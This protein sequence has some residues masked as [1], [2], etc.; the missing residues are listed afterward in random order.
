MRDETSWL[1]TWKLRKPVSVLCPYP[2]SSR[3]GVHLFLLSSDLL[4]LLHAAA[5]FSLFLRVPLL[6]S[7]GRRSDRWRLVPDA[8]VRQEAR[9][10]MG[11][12]SGSR[13][14]ATVIADVRKIIARPVSPRVRLITNPSREMAGV[15]TS[16]NNF[17]SVHS[18]T[19]VVKNI[20]R[21]IPYYR[22]FPSFNRRVIKA[23]EF[24]WKFPKVIWNTKLRI[25]SS[26]ENNDIWISFIPRFLIPLLPFDSPFCRIT[27]VT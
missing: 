11:Q 14:E 6:L 23:A 26:T 20:P 5:R 12:S 8:R 27:R 21:F 16:G 22:P 10:R 25:P 1:I 13:A 3:P 7:F 4:S 17:S 2:L 15:V 9:A 18:V 19:T 24:I